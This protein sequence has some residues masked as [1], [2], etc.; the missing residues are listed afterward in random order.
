MLSTC[1]SLQCRVG[2]GCIIQRHSTGVRLWGGGGGRRGDWIRYHTGFSL[3]INIHTFIYILQHVSHCL[4]TISALK[5]ND[6]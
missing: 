5:W 6:S 4:T 3:D 1:G 2:D